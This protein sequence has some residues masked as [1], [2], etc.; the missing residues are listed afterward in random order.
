M[1]IV[2]SEPVLREALGALL[3]AAGRRAWVGHWP[4]WPAASLPDPVPQAADGHPDPAPAPADTGLAVLELDGPDTPAGLAA[5]D[6][7]RRLA[8]LQR[9]VVFCARQHDHATLAAAQACGA[10]AYFVKPVE[11]A[12]LVRS[13]PVWQARAAELRQLRHERGSLLDALTASRLVGT[14][15]GMLSERH[16]LT[17][18]EAFDTL[19]RSARAE[20]RA[21]A[22]LARRVAAGGP[23]S[24]GA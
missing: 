9:P 11:P 18:E 22:E 13:M 14:A 24:E 4:D 6:L 8:A 21:V 7:A 5:L 15:V 2:E 23:L 16:R 10:F 20:R 3:R 19:R 17:P 12:L 1:L